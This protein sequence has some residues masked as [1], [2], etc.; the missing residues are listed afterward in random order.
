MNK[1]ATLKSLISI[2]AVM[3]KQI[4]LKHTVA[5]LGTSFILSMAVN[6]I[7]SA[8]ENASSLQRGTSSHIQTNNAAVSYA[9]LN[10]ENEEDV[11]VL[12]RRLEHATEKVCRLSASR[13]VISNSNR[14]HAY[15]QCYRETL[16]EAVEKIDNVDLS[17]IQA[18]I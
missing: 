1:I 17:R 5:V 7:V 15:K 14:S 3:L 12:Y 9:D 4:N 11:Q 16:A 2:S 8:G 10:L 6:P 18:A 13:I